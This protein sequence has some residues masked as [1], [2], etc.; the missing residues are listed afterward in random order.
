MIEKKRKYKL[1]DFDYLLPI[2]CEWRVCGSRITFFLSQEV[3]TDFV[4]VRQLRCRNSRPQV[5][6]SPIR[7]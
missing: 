7:G 3:T 2:W 6:G 1:H 4:M 5:G